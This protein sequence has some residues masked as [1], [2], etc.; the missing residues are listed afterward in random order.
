MQLNLINNYLF[1]Y[2]DW[3]NDGKANLA[4]IVYRVE[5]DMIYTVEGNS[6]DDGV[7]EKIYINNTVI[8]GYGVSI[9]WFTWKCRK[10]GA[11]LT[12]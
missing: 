1:N 12:F 5:N 10:Y 4:G 7:R 6:T 11:K 8:F 9:Y 3:W 2:D